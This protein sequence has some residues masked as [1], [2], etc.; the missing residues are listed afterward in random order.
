MKKIATL[1]FLLFI[2]FI[3]SHNRAKS[4]TVFEDISTE[5]EYPKYCYIKL[6]TNKIT[7]K[8]I[9]QQFPNM[10]IISISAYIDPVYKNKL[11]NIL[12]IYYFKEKSISENIDDFINLYHMTL[13]E[14]GI[15]ENL[16]STYTY[17]I[18]IEEIKIFCDEKTIHTLRNKNYDFVIR[19]K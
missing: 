13:K 3:F 11:K 16:K 8:N 2:I 9:N 6:L 7:T 5:R 1:F 14:K 4:I 17:G 19:N 18:P 10:Q 12:G 15:I